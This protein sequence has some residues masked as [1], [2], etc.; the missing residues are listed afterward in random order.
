MVAAFNPGQ[1]F[2][3]PFHNRL[4]NTGQACHLYAVAPVRSPFN[5]FTQKNDLIIP[6]LDGNV[7]ILDPWKRSRQ[8]CQFVIVGGEKSFDTGTTQ[9]V[10]ML[11]YRPGNAKAIVGARPSAN[12][13]HDHKTHAG[14]TIQD[15]GRL[16]HFNHESALALGKVV[17]STHAGEDP[18]CQ[19]DRGFGSRHKTAHVGHQYQQRHLTQ[20]RR[21]SGHVW[22]GYHQHLILNVVE[23]YGVGDKSFSGNHFFD[24]RMA[25]IGNL[26]D[27]LEID[28]RATIAILIGNFSQARQA[29]QTGDEAGGL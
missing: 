28:T 12:L 13:I 7:E 6:F 17:E 19:T 15:I 4:G 9:I 16:L 29:V 1:Y 11:R 23:P 5:Q 24:D 10:Q 2:F 21:F 27:A 25:P 20:H 14:G 22:T 26:N 8:V 3:G 18:V